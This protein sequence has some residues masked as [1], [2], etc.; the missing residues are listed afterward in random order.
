MTHKN[1]LKEIEQYYDKRA[2][3]HDGRK[4]AGQ[5][6]EKE[7]I[8]DI[9][10]EICKKIELSSEKKVL[11]IGCGSGILGRWINERCSAYFGLDIS[12]HMLKK[13]K[14]ETLENPHIVQALTNQIPTQD[15]TFDIVLINGVS[16]YFKNNIE[17]TSTLQEMSRV[18]KND[19]IIFIGE[20][21]VS[22]GIYWELVWFQNLSKSAQI[23]AKPYVKFR[24][25]LGKKFPKMA[26]KWKSIHNEISV[27]TL[28]KFFK[29]KGVLVESNSASQTIRRGKQGQ[30][31][32]GN[33]RKDFVIKL[34]G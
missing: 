15:N 33:H 21:I 29:D 5:W 10:S 22:S 20:N 6:N 1:T 8:P 12:C 3:H 13:F 34:N 9:C 26:G 7:I 17:L 19:A 28:K 18:A 23:I 16:M 27:E 2:K 32:K 30:K 11:E 25:N 24:H 14:D 4:A 31:Y